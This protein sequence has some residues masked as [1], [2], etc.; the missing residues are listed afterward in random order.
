MLLPN[1]VGKRAVPVVDIYIPTDARNGGEARVLPAIVLGR[2][3]RALGKR[4]VVALA[5]PVLSGPDVPATRA[6]A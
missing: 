1:I 2:V 3:L 4:L 6:E 5:I